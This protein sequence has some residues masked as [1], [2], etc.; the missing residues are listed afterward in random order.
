M[1]PTIH[2]EGLKRRT[3]VADNAVGQGPVFSRPGALA[4]DEFQGRVV[5]YQQRGLLIVEPGSGDRVIFSK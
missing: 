5:I 2:T 3:I 4:L 1:D